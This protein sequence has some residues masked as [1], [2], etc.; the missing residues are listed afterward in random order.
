MRFCCC[1]LERKGEGKFDEAVKTDVAVESKERPR[2]AHTLKRKELIAKLIRTY[3]ALTKGSDESSDAVEE[4]LEK[5]S[6][7]SASTSGKVSKETAEAIKGFDIPDSGKKHI[8]H[9][10]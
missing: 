6:S 8:S 2:D 1:I 3:D 9:P 5:L 7:R 10:K 4:E